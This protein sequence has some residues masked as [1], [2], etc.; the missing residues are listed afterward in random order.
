MR[1]DGNEARRIA[2]PPLSVVPGSVA[3]GW[4][5]FLRPRAEGLGTIEDASGRPIEGPGSGASAILAA[6]VSGDGA[7]WVSTRK[8]CGGV[9]RKPGAVRCCYPAA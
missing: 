7:L 6:C 2:P 4:P 1:Y 8:V 3:H 5:L 9:M